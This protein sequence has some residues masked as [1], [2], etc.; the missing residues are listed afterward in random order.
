MYIM[1]E[2]TDYSQMAG[3]RR[4]EK[5]VPQA[6]EDVGYRP[7]P[8]HSVHTKSRPASSGPARAQPGSNI[9]KEHRRRPG[10]DAQEV[11]Q[12]TASPAAAVQPVMRLGY[13]RS[14]RHDRLEGGDFL[15]A[16]LRKA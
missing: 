2:N 13:V 7:Q 14:L 8:E 15:K 1:M 11:R 5:D 10:E 16:G 3:H 4:R 12:S 6:I 9:A